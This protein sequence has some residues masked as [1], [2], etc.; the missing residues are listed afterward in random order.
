MAREVLE[1]RLQELEEEVKR[2]KEPLE[3]TLMDVRELISN[4]ENPFN[5]VAT[6]LGAT[7]Q[8][9]TG[10]N[11]SRQRSRGSTQDREK[12][13]EE[14]VRHEDGGGLLG[15]LACACILLR[16]LGRENTLKF[17]SSRL[18]AQL[19]PRETIERLMDAVEFLVKNAEPGGVYLPERCSLSYE[20]LLA[21][22]YVV[23]MMVSA[24]S[25]ERLFM[26]LLLGLKGHECGVGGEG[27]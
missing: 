9:D 1:K 23:S 21:A 15:L 7:Y 2:L 19:A 12:P 24:P 10:R 26:A 3:S 22:S 18:V 13:L 27:R 4:L 5:Y 6:L 16:L 14:Q 8:V 17:L 11:N 20:S 25:D